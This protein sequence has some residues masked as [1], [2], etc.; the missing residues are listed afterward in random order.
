MLDCMGFGNAALLK[1][2]PLAAA[3]F[4]RCARVS[5]SNAADHDKAMV[6]EAF[7][8]IRCNHYGDA[9]QTL[10]TTKA[11]TPGNGAQLLR[12]I[13]AAL[14]RMEDWGLAHRKARELETIDPDRTRQLGLVPETQKRLNE[15]LLGDYDIDGLRYA[16]GIEQ[17]TGALSGIGLF[18]KS[19]AFPG[20]LLLVE[21]AFALTQPG[22]HA[23]SENLRHTNPRH[24][25]IKNRLMTLLDK[26]ADKAV[27][28]P[29]H[30][31]DLFS[32]CSGARDGPPVKVSGTPTFETDRAQRIHIRNAH[33]T[34]VGACHV[35][36]D[37]FDPSCP[38][39]HVIK[40]SFKPEQQC[41]GIWLEGP[42]F[43]H[44]CVPNA[45]W[46]WISN[47]MV[48]RAARPLAAD[49]ELTISY[50]PPNQ[51]FDE[52]LKSLAE[53]GFVCHCPLC[54]PECELTLTQISSRRILDKLDIRIANLPSLDL[55]K[56]SK[57][58]LRTFHNHL[59]LA[60]PSKLYADQ[61]LPAPCLSG[62]LLNLAHMTLGPSI[63]AWNRASASARA[64][65]SN[66]LHA[67]LSLAL[68]VHIAY[69]KSSS[70]CEII[71]GPHSCA[72]FVGIHTL[73]A[74]AELAHLSPVPKEKARCPS[75]KYCA[76]AM[77][78]ICYGESVSFQRKH[79]A[80]ACKDDK[81]ENG[82]KPGEEEWVKCVKQAEEKGKAAWEFCKSEK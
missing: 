3:H 73:I 43:N 78:L 28:E 29:A 20:S 41:L 15:H 24:P 22:E 53:N 30:L 57:T 48:V 26:L 16:A 47:V 51:T 61:A 34:F 6:K 66:Y 2:A 10:S 5:A 82:K 75:L 56:H 54:E 37:V 76:K 64:K 49:E 69:A 27:T 67:C 31:R 79:Q 8:Y 7:A 14:T 1:N 36:H 33:S 68:Q 4:Y 59:H 9:L 12:L 32:L 70:Y 77:Y 62:P 55:A 18:L 46:S 21:K 42:R 63:P 39:E 25:A 60:Y 72:R 58:T 45:Q 80:Y 44:S 35:Q 50:A 71:H 17:R 38:D 11:A 52:R 74:L 19:S 81:P 23:G 40:W 65:A 13:Y